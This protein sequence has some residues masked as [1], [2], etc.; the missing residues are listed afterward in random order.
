MAS[1]AQRQQQL[2]ESGLLNG[3]GSVNAG[4]KLDGVE[5]VFVKYM[6]ILVERLQDNLNKEHAVPGGFTASSIGTGALSSS[7]RF[8]YKKMG[9]TYVGDIYML[10]YAD[11]IDQGVKGI[12][13]TYPSSAGSPYQFK[14][15]FP[16]KKMQASLILWVRAKNIF[17]KHTSP[18]GLLR[19]KTK[20]AL[21][22]KVKQTSLAIAIG[23]G[24]KRKGIYGTHFKSVSVDSIMSEMNAELAKAAAHD[25]SI[26]IKTSLN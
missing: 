4:L 26:N 19:H 7:I 25:I 23:M 11:Y 6:G 24:I 1:E 18:I 22:T 3:L 8:Q 21:S 14:T 10:D 9:Q 13:S 17:D 20:Q 16:S 12:K 5:K 15:A 2:I